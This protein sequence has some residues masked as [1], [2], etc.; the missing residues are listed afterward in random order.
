M[1]VILSLFNDKCI[2]PMALNSK[3]IEELNQE[4]RA[5]L[6]SILQ[7]EYLVDIF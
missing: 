1:Q 3:D 4:K 6:I 5:S 7:H 2:L